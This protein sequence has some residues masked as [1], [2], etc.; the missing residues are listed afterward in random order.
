M[1][2]SV[3]RCEL[4]SQEKEGDFDWLIVPFLKVFS[5]QF[6]HGG[7]ACCVWEGTL[8]F[9]AF[10]FLSMSLKNCLCCNL[11]M[12]VFSVLRLNRAKLAW[13]LTRHWMFSD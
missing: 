10:V 8:A 11:F 12:S 6:P 3:H 7:V 13:S 9:M 1:C 4:C 2:P 5:G